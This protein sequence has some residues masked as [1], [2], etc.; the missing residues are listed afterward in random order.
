MR[1][2]KSDFGEEQL[3]SN[4]SMCIERLRKIFFPT[5][6]HAAATCP[7]FVITLWTFREQIYCLHSALSTLL[8]VLLSEFIAPIFWS[9]FS[10]LGIPWKGNSFCLT[11]SMQPPHLSSHCTLTSQEASASWAIPESRNSP[12]VLARDT[13][14][15]LSPCS[16]LLASEE[17]YF[18]L[19]CK[20]SQ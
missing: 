16:Q 2:A 5:M 6:S 10:S 1:R 15:S 13:L 19:L 17:L 11:A 20:V 9:H 18:Y 8:T 14:P 3:R 7:Q 12:G 4:N